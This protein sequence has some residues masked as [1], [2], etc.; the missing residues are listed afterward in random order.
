[1]CRNFLGFGQQKLTC[2]HCRIVLTCKHIT[3]RDEVNLKRKGNR[4]MKN[5]YA[6]TPNTAKGFDAAGF[7][8]VKAGATF[9]HAIEETGQAIYMALEA[10][11]KGIEINFKGEDQAKAL[12]DF[13]ASFDAAFYAASVKRK[14]AILLARTKQVKLSDGERADIEASAK[15]LTKATKSL[16][17]AVLE[18]RLF[19]N[20]GTIS[21]NARDYKADHEL[22]INGGEKKKP[23]KKNGNDS[24][25]NSTELVKTIEGFNALI[26]SVIN[27]GINS[28]NPEVIAK[29]ES[30][31]AFLNGATK[32]KAK[33]KAAGLGAALL[34]ASA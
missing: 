12:A 9:A 18:I 17:K 8:A 34:K 21:Q 25:I 1:L 4:T 32:G 3:S 11:A 29:A 23:K 14:T 7:D 20:G 15:N 22:S 31:N 33:G 27:A 10:I 16:Y 13:L 24:V 28:G 26:S 6:L 30:I 2:R 5:V 19:K